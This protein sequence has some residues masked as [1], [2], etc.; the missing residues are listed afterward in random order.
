MIVPTPYLLILGGMC[1]Q[2]SR[3]YGLYIKRYIAV[4]LTFFLSL[5][6][7][8]KPVKTRRTSLNNNRTAYCVPTEDRNAR[9]DTHGVS[10]V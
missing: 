4:R 10:R 8:L 5:S 9:D 7:F 1:L 2:V 6:F 3:R